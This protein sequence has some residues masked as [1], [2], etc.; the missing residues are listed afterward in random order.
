MKE[1]STLSG[2]Y[3]DTVSN[4]LIHFFPDIIIMAQQQVPAMF[5][6]HEHCIRDSSCHFLSARIGWHWIILCMKYQRRDGYRFKGNSV[7]LRV[8]GICVEQDTSGPGNRGEEGLAERSIPFPL[9]LRHGLPEI[10]RY[11][12][13][14]H[15]R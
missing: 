9:L 14:R 7:N 2:R 15:H 6:S 5:I 10:I 3:G 11:A 12:G 8:R 1:K 4:K 13:N